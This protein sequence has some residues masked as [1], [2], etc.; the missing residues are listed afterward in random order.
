MNAPTTERIEISARAL[1]H[2]ALENYVP[3]TREQEREYVETG[4]R[5]LLVT[6]HLRFGVSYAKRYRRRASM[7]DLIQQANIGLVVASERFDPDQGVRFMTYAGHWVRHHIER[8]LQDTARIVRLPVHSAP[9]AVALYKG[10]AKTPEDLV[11][12][13]GIGLNT[14]KDIVRTATSKP[15][16]IDFE[17]ED[18]ARFEL[19]DMTESPEELFV[20]ED[21]QAKLRAEVEKALARLTPKE[22]EII[23]RRFLSADDEAGETLEEVGDTHDVSRERIRQIQVKAIAK[24]RRYLAHVRPEPTFVDDPTERFEARKRSER[25]AA[26]ALR[27]ERRA[28]K[29]K[30]TDEQKEAAMVRVD[31]GETIAAV[32]RDIGCSGALIALWRTGRNG[33]KP[34]PKT[35]RKAAA[36]EK[37]AAALENPPKTKRAKT[38]ADVAVRHTSPAARLDPLDVIEAWA[39]PYALGLAVEAIHV[40]DVD[41][42]IVALERYRARRA[43]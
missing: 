17:P 1:Y 5:D 13:F 29:S 34:K 25:E 31:N 12:I 23:E 24:L 8:Y 32:A 20:D 26:A 14:A 30:F 39:L 42:A 37:V 28:M 3:V 19:P 21:A 4:R 43:A 2:R 33:G 18:G 22:R 36:R 16:S 38:I 7:E 40:G 15:F 27:E 10:D 9:A 35:A 41:R 6:S 11:R